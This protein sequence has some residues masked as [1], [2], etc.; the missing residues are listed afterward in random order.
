MNKLPLLAFAALLINVAGA[1][2]NSHPSPK[3][4]ATSSSSSTVLQMANDEDLL[5]WARSSRSAGANDN[6]VELMRPIGVVLAEDDKGNVFVETLAPNGN[7][8]RSGKVGI[9]R[10]TATLVY[11]VEHKQQQ[12]PKGFTV[13]YR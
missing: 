4:V 5:R 1:F 7:A 12:I 2:T 6:L 10:L 8:A 13:F 9:S 11:R 3:S